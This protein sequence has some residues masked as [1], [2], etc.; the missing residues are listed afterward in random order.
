MKIDSPLTGSHVGSCTNTTAGWAANLLLTIH[1]V[2]ATALHGDGAHF[3]QLA[4][5][6]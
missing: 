5:C 3:L 2:T 1:G 4:P 6:A